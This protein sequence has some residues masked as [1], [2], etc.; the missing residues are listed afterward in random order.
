MYSQRNVTLHARAVPVERRLPVFVK[1][2]TRTE[3]SLD[4]EANRVEVGFGA[5]WSGSQEIQLIRC[6]CPSS[7]A[8]SAPVSG[9]QTTTMLSNP[10]DANE[11]PSEGNKTRSED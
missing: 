7:L 1:S 11:V 4:A 8:F 6:L 9:S 10:P 2:H 5:K 3:P